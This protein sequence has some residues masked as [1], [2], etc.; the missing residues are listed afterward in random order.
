VRIGGS[1]V[2]EI[3]SWR[4]QT[5]FKGDVLLTHIQLRLLHTTISPNLRHNKNMEQRRR[6]GGTHFFLI[7]NVKKRREKVLEV[8]F[9]FLF[10]GGSSIVHS[11]LFHVLHSVLES[12]CDYDNTKPLDKR[13]RNGKKNSLNRRK[14][15]QDLPHPHNFWIDVVRCST[16][17]HES[18]TH[19]HLFRFFKK[20]RTNTEIHVNKVAKNDPTIVSM[21]CQQA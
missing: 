1:D 15:Q 19:T 9:L 20:T 17:T 2:L 14:V 6:R 3:D 16:S 18:G 4:I 13:T 8:F 7:E 11:P 21:C 5:P 12:T 10:S